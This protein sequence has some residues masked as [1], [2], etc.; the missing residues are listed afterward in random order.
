MSITPSSKVPTK[1]ATSRSRLERGSDS[2]N[3]RISMLA[4]KFPEGGRYSEQIRP[5]SIYIGHSQEAQRLGAGSWPAHISK[6]SRHSSQ[7]SSP[8]I[9]YQ[10][11]GHD[12]GLTHNLINSIAHDKPRDLRRAN[13]CHRG[14]SKS[15]K[16]TS[17]SSS[18][19][20]T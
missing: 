11:I 20:C 18:K 17:T 10:D 14:Q 9:A 5:K 2:H 19:K 12:L 6:D 16:S 8:H 3:S 15:K 4:Q 1:P 7:P 13:S